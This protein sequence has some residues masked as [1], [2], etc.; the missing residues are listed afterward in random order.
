MDALEYYFKQMQKPIERAKDL[1]LGAHY[2]LLPP[3]GEVL[4]AIGVEGDLDDVMP[5]DLSD[6]QLAK[7]AK[8]VAPHEEAIEAHIW[9]T[10]PEDSRTWMA[11]TP[12][13]RRKHP[14]WVIHCTTPGSAGEIMNYGFIYGAQIDTLAHTVHRHDRMDGAGYNFGYSL[15]IAPRDVLKRYGGDCVIALVPDSMLINHSAD[16]EQQTIFWGPSVDTDRIFLVSYRNGAYMLDFDG[17][18]LDD[19]EYDR[20]FSDGLETLDDVVAVLDAELSRR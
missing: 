20:I 13:Q 17:S 4:S 19:D 10:A 1:I 8:L 9:R 7:A 16:E 11:I 2:S 5:W 14:E 18:H 3:W 15:D 12:I 6:A